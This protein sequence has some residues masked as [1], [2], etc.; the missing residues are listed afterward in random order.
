GGA[1]AKLTMKYTGLFQTRR[2]SVKKSGTPEITFTYDR[3]GI[4]PSSQRP[5]AAGAHPA[6]FTYTPGAELVSLRRGDSTFYYIRDRLGSVVALIEFDS[7]TGAS[8]VANRYQYSPW[9]EILAQKEAVPQP[10]K[11]TGAEYEPSTNLYKMG[12]RYYDPTVG[13]FTQLD[14]R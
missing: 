5:G 4:G 13:R 6:F 9:G 14:L 2:V 1:A 12:A 7:K 3:T 8:V 11:F 10:F